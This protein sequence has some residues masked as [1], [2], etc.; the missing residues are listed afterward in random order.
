M[1]SE[2]SKGHDVFLFLRMFFMGLAASLQYRLRH[3]SVDDELCFHLIRL[4]AVRNTF[5]P[6]ARLPLQ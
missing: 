1:H 3:G 5:A 4:D 6:E 2:I